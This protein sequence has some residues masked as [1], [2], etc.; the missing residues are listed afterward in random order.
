MSFTVVG[1]RDRIQNQPSKSLDQ[2]GLSTARSDIAARRTRLHV[3]GKLGILVLPFVGFHVFSLFRKIKSRW[4]GWAAF[5]LA[6]RHRLIVRQ[7][8]A[9]FSRFRRR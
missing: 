7:D 4:R 6:S 9:I 2:L 1:L 8:Q 3:T 5:R